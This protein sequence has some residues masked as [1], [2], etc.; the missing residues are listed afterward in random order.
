MTDQFAFPGCFISDSILTDWAMPG[1]KE[2]VAASVRDATF[3]SRLTAMRLVDWYAVPRSH[4]DGWPTLPL[5]GF[6]VDALVTAWGIGLEVERRREAAMV[7]R[8]S[9]FRP[10]TKL[11]A[12][13]IGRSERTTLRRRSQP[14]PVQPD[15][16]RDDEVAAEVTDLMNRNGCGSWA[17]EALLELHA[18]LQWFTDRRKP[19]PLAVWLACVCSLGLGYPDGRLT[20]ETV[21]A[22]NHG[23]AKPDARRA[24]ARIKGRA[25]AAGITLSNRALAKHEEVGVSRAAVDDWSGDDEWNAN[26]RWQETIAGAEQRGRQIAAARRREEAEQFDAELERTGLDPLDL[27]RIMRDRRRAAAAYGDEVAGR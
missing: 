7:R 21:K 26:V 13:E 14:T 9:Q 3:A 11:I 10:N 1:A 4:L 25:R 23:I 20:V 24:A 2:I 6:L 22:R 18:A 15:G 8:R 19:I 16:V 12:S 27:I 17:P 5:E